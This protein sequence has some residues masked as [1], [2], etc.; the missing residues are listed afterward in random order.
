MCHLQCVCTQTI[1]T[2]EICIQSLFWELI[3]VCFLKINSFHYHYYCYKMN[4][5]KWTFFSSF[6][7][8][9][10]IIIII[11]HKKNRNWLQNYEFSISR[12]QIITIYVNLKWAV[13]KKKKNLLFVSKLDF[14]FV[15]LF[16]LGYIVWSVNLVIFK[17]KHPMM[18]ICAV[19]NIEFFFCSNQKP[20]IRLKR[21]E[22]FF[23]Y[24]SLVLET[25]FEV[26]FSVY[27]S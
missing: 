14:F 19:F 8:E 23:I 24:S 17:C 5:M 2:D 4:L 20:L 15:S 1:Y 18:E 3:P 9:T 11:D 7:D 10:I 13:S 27:F 21:V 6:A 16:F 26:F 12:G 25:D 22:F